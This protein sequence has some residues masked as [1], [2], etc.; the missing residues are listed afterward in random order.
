[1]SVATVVGLLIVTAACGD[2]GPERTAGQTVALDS[3]TAP[4]TATAHPSPSASAFECV[5]PLAEIV[6]LAAG[7]GLPGT[8]VRLRIEGFPPDA[9]LTVTLGYMDDEGIRLSMG[10]GRSDAHGDGFLLG[11]IPVDAPFGEGILNVSAGEA[12][13]AEAYISVVGSLEAIGI[14]DDTVVP[15]QQVTIRASG[16]AP[17]DTVAVIL[18]GDV[19]D[20]ACQCRALAEARANAVG[21]V[22]MVARIPPDVP[23]GAHFLTVNGDSFDFMHDVGLTVHITVDR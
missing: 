16:F 17:E 22:E 9:A 6:P 12:C 5:E 21:F 15:G 14:D 3:S 10:T 23:A 19:R 13:G 4:P 18:D 20:A 2:S 1:L 7:V 8:T 11:V